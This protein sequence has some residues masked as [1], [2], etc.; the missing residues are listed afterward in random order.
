MTGLI[1]RFS[2][3]LALLSVCSV[4]GATFDRKR[5]SETADRQLAVVEEV[6]AGNG[7]VPWWERE[8]DCGETNS[9]SSASAQALGGPNG[10][11]GIKKKA[12]GNTNVYIIAVKG[13]VPSA[14]FLKE[15]FLA[16]RSLEKTRP[17]PFDFMAGWPK[18]YGPGSHDGVYAALLDR[19]ISFD[20]I[21]K[22]TGSDKNVISFMATPGAWGEWG[23]KSYT[24]VFDGK[25]NVEVG[26]GWWEGNTK[27]SVYVGDIDSSRGYLNSAYGSK[28]EA[29]SDDYRPL[30]PEGSGDILGPT[31]RCDQPDESNAVLVKEGSASSFNLTH[32]NQTASDES[33][34]PSNKKHVY[35]TNAQEQAYLYLHMTKFKDVRYNDYSPI[36]DPGAPWKTFVGIVTDIAMDLLGL[37]PSPANTEHTCYLGMHD[38][39]DAANSEWFFFGTEVEHAF[40]TMFFTWGKSLY[41]FPQTEF[42]GDTDKSWLL[43]RSKAQLCVADYGTRE[44]NPHDCKPFQLVVDPDEAE[45]EVDERIK[46]GHKV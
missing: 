27:V 6:K 43:H 16:M 25:E 4:F 15:K 42:K 38:Y 32:Q 26:L 11:K 45:K 31:K 24:N 37:S 14:E 8:S 20:E 9:T 30:M 36:I 2:I 19:V 29:H 33:S 13:P 34:A 17:G 35:I 28:E 5:L 41:M 39:V 7:T 18:Y 40:I 46:N 12:V 44:K 23:V 3:I 22:V 21:K 1:R 10:S